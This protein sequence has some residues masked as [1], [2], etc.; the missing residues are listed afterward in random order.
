MAGK[1]RLE[2]LVTQRYRLDEI[3]EAYA[4]MLTGPRPAQCGAR[5]ELC[6][7]IDEITQAAQCYG[8]KPNADKVRFIAMAET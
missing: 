7:L 3:N 1:L 4:S 8:Y 6:R 2:E 5:R